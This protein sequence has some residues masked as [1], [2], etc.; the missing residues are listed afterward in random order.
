[1]IACRPKPLCLALALSLLVAAPLAAREPLLMEGKQTLYQRVLIRDATER[2]DAPD[3]AAGSLL[4]P[5]QPL[6]VYA[7]D[8]V[9]I[10]AGLDDQGS[11]LFWIREETSVPWNQNIVATFEGSENVGRVLFFANE[12]AVYDVVESEAPEVLAGE[13]RAAALAA[14]AGGPPSED[15]VALGPRAT[16]DLRENLYVMPILQSE[17]AV[18]E[19]NG[20]YVNI[21]KLAVA[22]AGAQASAASAG[23]VIEEA[24]VALPDT[25][26]G[27]FRAGVVFVVDTT[28][29]MEKYITATHDALREVYG[30]FRERNLEDAVSFGLIGYRDSLIAAPDLGYDTRTFVTLE[31][32]SAPGAFLDGIARMTEADRPSRNFREDSYA[33]IEHALRDLDWSPYGARFIVLVTDASPREAADEFSA[34]GMTGRA[35]NSLVKERLGAAVAVLHLRTTAGADDHDKAEA[36]YRDLTRQANQSALYFPVKDGDP[37]L[38]RGAA[39]GLAEVIAE[40]VYDFRAPEGAAGLIQEAPLQEASASDG[41]DDSDGMAQALRSAGRTMQLAY[42]GRAAGV[43]APDVFEAYV[44]DRDFDRPGLKPL[45]IRLLISKRDLSDLSEAM[46]IIIAKGEENVLSTDQMFNQVLSAAADMSRRPDQVA[47]NADT[48]LAEAVSV[49]EM[50]DGLPYK[51][52]IMTVTEEDWIAMNIAEQQTILN[53]LADK[54]EL[55]ARFNEATDQWVDYL[56]TGAVAENL[57]YPMRLDDLP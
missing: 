31:E 35:V 3:G 36:A 24:A 9:W 6:F 28:I 8:G 4:S 20:A 26:R 30:A 55:Y 40:Q 38:Y 32:G 5:L 13:A 43:Q 57:L 15:V 56:G 7:R 17:E 48:T 12:D 52:Q 11:D 47:R 29:S 14:E 37:G 2:H 49:E 34:T 25:E 18:L 33:A 19:T 1:M 53:G 45:S 51:S 21:L 23:R 50:L 39:R 16:P 27:A 54:I 10:Q 41:T 44:A 22:R 46:K 42:L